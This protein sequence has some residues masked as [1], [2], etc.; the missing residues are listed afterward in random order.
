MAKPIPPEYVYDLITVATPALS[1]DG[2]RLAFV[3]SAVDI[4]EMEYRTTVM[5]ADLPGGTPRKVAHCKRH[6]NPSRPTH[7]RYSARY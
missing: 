6:H 7:R 2:S 1:P 5:M 4:D 3:R